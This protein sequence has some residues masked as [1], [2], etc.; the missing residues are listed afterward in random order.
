[1]HI[2]LSSIHVSKYGERAPKENT[3]DR[4]CERRFIFS[5]ARTH[6]QVT[7][8]NAKDQTRERENSAL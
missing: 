8:V 6:C 5:P 2:F 7:E 3:H 1:M 4:G